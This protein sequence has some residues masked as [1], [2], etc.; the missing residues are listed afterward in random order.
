MSVS[1]QVRRASEGISNY[2]L[3]AGFLYGLFIEP[4]DEGD[5]F[6][7]NISSHS[8]KYYI[9]LYPRKHTFLLNFV[10]TFQFGLT[11]GDMKLRITRIWDFV[12][13]VFQKNI[14]EHNV[15]ESRSVFTHR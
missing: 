15:S 3:H 7:R 8:K 9:A 5:N 12:H 2:L 14:K 1:Y 6:F 13:L 11:S 4:E 10:Y